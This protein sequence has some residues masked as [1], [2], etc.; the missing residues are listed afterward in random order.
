MR[1]G[2]KEFDDFLIDCF[3]LFEVQL[4]YEFLLQIHNNQLSELSEQLVL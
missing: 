3:E 4:A 1:N 2:L